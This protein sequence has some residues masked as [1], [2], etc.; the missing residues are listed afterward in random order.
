MQDNNNITIM[1]TLI[2]LS[3]SLVKLLDVLVKKILPKKQILS[4][5]ELDVLKRNNEMLNSITHK[6]SEESLLTNQEQ[7]WLKNLH[8]LHDK[9]DKDGIPLWY[10]PR[11]FIDTQ[12]EVIQILSNISKLQE[13]TTYVLESILKKIEK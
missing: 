11:S 10:V 13:K 4:D 12:K 7:E 3:L 8:N 9:T 1:F 6:V 2:V 5:E